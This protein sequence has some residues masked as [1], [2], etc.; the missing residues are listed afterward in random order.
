MD[1]RSDE[2]S[3]DGYLPFRESDLFKKMKA[4]NVPLLSSS[5]DDLRLLANQMIDLA[6]AIDPRVS[7]ELPR[8]RTLGAEVVAIINAEYLPNT[9]KPATY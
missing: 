1:A 2:D 6:D 9:A 7:S 4:Q 5:P 8:L 3:I